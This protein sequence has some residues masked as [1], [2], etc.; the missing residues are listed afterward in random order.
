MRPTRLRRDWS[1]R[2]IALAHALL[3]VEASVGPCGHS[4]IYTTDPSIDLD[5]WVEP[6]VVAH[7]AYC[8]ARDL[9]RRENDDSDRDPGDVIALVNTKPAKKRRP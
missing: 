2:D 6:Q 3:E 9:Y 8:E 1:A 4:H 5:G 7:C